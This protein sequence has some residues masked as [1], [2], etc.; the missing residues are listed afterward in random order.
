MLRTLTVW[1]FALLEHVKVDFGSGLNILTGETGAGKSILID[2]L[3]SVLGC[4]LSASSIRSGCEWLR[5]EAVFGLENQKTLREILEEQAIPVE[6]EELIVTRQISHKGKNSV[7]LN[8]CRV[9][10]SFLRDLG[11][12]LVD[13]HGQNENLALL[14]PENQLRL[15]DQSDA[16]IETQLTV[17]QK[18]FSV[19]NMC[20]KKLR[21]KKEEARNNAERLDLLHWQEKE[22]EEAHLKEGEDEA[23]EAEIRKL[24]NAEKISSFVEESYAL[25]NGDPGGKALNILTALSK[26]K[27][28]ME[29]LS[30][31][32]DGLENAYKM[33]ENSYCELQESSYEIRDYA[34]DM[35]FDSQ[36]LDMLEN[37]LDA[38]DKL[39]KKYGATVADV[40]AYL[41]NVKDELDRIENYDID[42]RD[43]EMELEQS[44][45]DMKKEAEKLTTL[46]EGAARHLSARICDQIKELGMAKAQFSIVLKTLTE[47]SINGADAIVMLFSANA[48]EK[49]QP[50]QDV[51]SGGELSRVVLAIKA[52]SAA[53]D[54]SPPS[55]VFDEIDTGI[56]GKT[57]RMVAERIAMVAL[58]RQVLCITHLPQIACMAN[59]H[60]Y[61]RKETTGE[62]TTTEVQILSENERINE[63][64]RMASGSDITMAALDNAREMVDNARIKQAEISRKFMK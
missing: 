6:E 1:N 33:I 53:G 60:L 56:G 58:H 35:E 36:R 59:T 64:A 9:T 29:A 49:E 22:I 13:I 46:R 5:V 39:R 21:Q 27:K 15:L 26:V 24:S 28:N 45:T 12:H 40:L 63:I 23:I 20:K 62:R 3:G 50:L 54:D 8:G 7:L 14:R 44:T 25:L 11:A 48:G 51:A 52:V 37:R 19:W 55:M 32:D 47:Y 42:V 43:L 41:A 31:F 57:A 18:S 16:R 2:A 61:I 4:R 34:S 30:R 10:L 17:Y 38:I